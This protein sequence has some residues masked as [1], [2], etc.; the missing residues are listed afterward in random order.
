MPFYYVLRKQTPEVRRR[1]AEGLLRLRDQFLADKVPNRTVSDTLLLAT[2]NIRE[3]DSSKYGERSPESLYYI[4]EILSHFDLIAIQEVREDLKA[5]DEVQAILGGWWKYLVTD[6]TYGAGGN[7]ERMAFMYDSRKVTFGGLAGE[8]VLPDSKQE[9]V[10]QFARTPFI[11][12]FKAGWT[13]FNLCTVHIYYGTADKDDP[14]RIQEIRNLAQLLAR[15]GR[16][17]DLDQPARPDGKVT[18]VRNVSAENLILLGDFNI[19]GREDQTM[20][21]LTDAGFIV[22]EEIQPLE[23]SNLKQDRHYD[24]MAFLVEPRRFG[25]TGRAGVFNFYQSIYGEDQEVV[26]E[27][28]MGPKYQAAKNR[29]RYYKDWRTY[30]MSDHLLLW[31]EL[32]IDF[33]R[34]YLDELKAGDQA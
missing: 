34:E 22:P 8:V 5:L 1:T 17:G 7:G 4:A 6:V 30:Q 26:Y 15:K 11:C 20:K 24:Q 29:S 10:L 3:F 9:R 25:T 32:K 33:G 27:A 13:K 14:R 19:F 12:G 18:A 16:G 21:A 31:V 28:D 23:G 2:W